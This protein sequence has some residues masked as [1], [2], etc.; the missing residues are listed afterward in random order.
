MCA[1]WVWGV[2]VGVMVPLLTGGGGKE[3]CTGEEGF[4]I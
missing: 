3:A 1:G 4:A 2:G